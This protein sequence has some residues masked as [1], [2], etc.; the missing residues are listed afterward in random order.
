MSRGGEGGK[1]VDGGV[2]DEQKIRQDQPDEQEVSSAF[3]EEK[4][5]GFLSHRRR[6]CYPIDY[7][8]LEGRSE[9]Q[10]NSFR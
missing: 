9:R 1:V 4:Q 5:K 8:P 10:S 6:L 2:G 3:A 7:T